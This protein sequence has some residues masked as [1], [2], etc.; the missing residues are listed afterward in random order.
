MHFEANSNKNAENAI[1]I[2]IDIMKENN[3]VEIVSSTNKRYRVLEYDPKT[4]MC[5]AVPFED[6]ETQMMPDLD[7]YNDLLMSEI[8]DLKDL[9]ITFSKKMNFMLDVQ[10]LPKE[11]EAR[12]HK[13]VKGIEAP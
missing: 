2:E 11:I 1:G 7:K 6:D 8:N 5:E 10:I 12:Y 4:D 3:N 9:W 13:N